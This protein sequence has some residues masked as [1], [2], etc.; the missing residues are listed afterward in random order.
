[1]LD[2]FYS[3]SGTLATIEW[4][5]DNTA[6]TFTAGV[7]GTLIDVGA[8]LV[9]L[10]LVASIANDAGVQ[11]SGDILGAYSRGQFRGANTPP[12]WVSLIR[13]FDLKLPAL[14]DRLPAS[15]PSILGLFGLGLVLVSLAKRG[16]CPAL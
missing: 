13:E 7:S 1:M 5:C 12:V 2:Q 8:D 15:E 16:T 10:A 3:G 14:A 9:A 11:R 4:C 6:Q